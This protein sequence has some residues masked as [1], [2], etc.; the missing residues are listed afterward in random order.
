MLQPIITPTPRGTRLIAPGEC[1][2]AMSRRR[3][4]RAS[5]RSAGAPST[6][7]ISSPTAL[8]NLTSWF[9]ADLGVTL[10]TTTVS[11]WADQ[12]GAAI[13]P[14]VSQGTGAN[15]P[16]FVASG[17]G[18]NADISYG[19]SHFLFGNSSLL[20]TTAFTQFTIFKTSLSGTQF[21]FGM[22]FNDYHYSLFINVDS[23]H[24]GAITGLTNAAATVVSP[25]SYA[26]GNPHAAIL[27][28]NG[29]TLSL[30]VDNASSAVGS[31]A[32]S[33]T[34]TNAVGDLNSFG[35]SKG[36]AA[37]DRLF[38]GNIPEGGTYSVAYSGAQLA[39]LMG[40]LKKR[41]GI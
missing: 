33:G 11:A 40:Y 26:D 39:G 6:P 7:P 30:Y 24:P 25:S 1:W 10:N 18:G 5:R 22:Q 28:Y 2:E 27:V 14:S 17:I 3:N 32:A 31:V 12:S 4:P 38:T 34:I 36:A 29:S 16:T 20:A 9:R 15:Q 41:A 37:N 35:T 8:A 21:I 13:C 19:G 23:S